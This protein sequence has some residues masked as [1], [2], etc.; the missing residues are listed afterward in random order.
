[1]VSPSGLARVSACLRSETLEHTHEVNEAAHLGTVAHRFLCN[2]LLHGLE[3]SLA[4]ENE[5]DR[6]WLVGIDIERLPAFRPELYAPEVSF[7]MDFS[8]GKARELGRN[9]SRQ[10]ARALAKPGEMVGTADVA[11][12]TPEAFVALDYKTGYS[13]VDPPSVNWQ[14]LTYALMGARAYGKDDAIVGIVRARADGMVWKETFHADLFRLEQHEAELRELLEKRDRI[15]EAMKAGAPLPPFSEGTHCNY[16]PARFRCP[17]KTL[18]L[19][20]LART[21][22][23]EINPETG[24]EVEMQRIGDSL[25]LET[26]PLIWEKLKFAEK[27]VER[28]KAEVKEF[29]RVNPIPLGGGFILGERVATTETLVPERARKV[30]DFA[31][32]PQMSSIVAGEAIET[33]ESLTK[34]ALQSSVRKYILPTLPK[35][36]QKISKVFAALLERMRTGGAV[37]VKS[38][39]RVDEHKVEKPLDVELLVVPVEAAAEAA[40]E[41]A[42]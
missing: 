27:M 39:R 20:A 4:L 36:E 42:A 22:P 1:M 5:N 15:L 25:T 13:F 28:L 7:A 34:S 29:A 41:E 16:C 24:E 11:G 10:E 33:K 19:V 35:S 18:Q 23:H 2:V 9:L 37:S 8:T 32:G 14:V 40:P 30:L 6:E 12:V 26:A 38:S 17:S 31:F 3:E 21:L